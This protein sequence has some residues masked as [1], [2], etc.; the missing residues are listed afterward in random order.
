M[1]DAEIARYYDRLNRWNAFARVAGYGGGSERLT[2]HRALADPAA[3]G[4]PTT[5]RLHDILLARLP[6]SVKALPRPRV[7]DAGCGLGGTM[8]MLARRLDAR[9]VGI[10]LSSSQ[11]GTA[12]AAIEIAGL[13]ESAEVRVQSYD[14]PPPGPFDLVVA[15]ESL[16]HSQA[17]AGSVSALVGT[18]TPGGTLVVVDDM[19][20]PEAEGSTDLDAFRRGW[21][22]PV[23]WTLPQYLTALTALHCETVDVLDL[24]PDVRPRPLTRIAALEGLNRLVHAV[25]LDGLRQVMD[26]HLGGLALER[27]SRQGVM[28]YRMLI[29]SRGRERM[30]GE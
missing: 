18:L 1:S 19:P 2:V 26:S 12:R 5:T 30:P 3:D 8:I 7:L 27:M 10:T 9:V 14:E 23:L 4:R 21:Q 13:R 17:P 16:A 15:I 24:S 25:P 6:A 11:A 28:R 29:A 20:E 22:A